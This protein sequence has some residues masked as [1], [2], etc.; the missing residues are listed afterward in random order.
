MAKKKVEQR[1]LSEEERRQ[2]AWKQ[3]AARGR[4]ERNVPLPTES[5]RLSPG[6]EL[7]LGNLEDV[8]VLETSEDGRF[9]LLSY[10]RTDNNYGKPIVTKNNYGVWAWIECFKKSE[11]VDTEFRRKKSLAPAFMNSD[12]RSLLS[13][14]FYRGVI[15]N[16]DYQREYV[17]SQEDKE[18]LIESV[19]KERNLGTFLFVEHP[20]EKYEG[21]LEILDGK[22]RLG[23]LAD[24]Y[25]SKF[26]Y[27]GRYFHELDRMDKHAFMGTMVQFAHLN[28]SRMTKAELLQVF[29]DVNHRGVPQ[30]NEHIKKVERMLE[31]E[32]AKESVAVRKAAKP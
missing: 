14:V 18:A 28:G 23:A 22:Q 17:W 1:E 32:L 15:D 19:F 24:F 27:K 4:E 8:V 2:E 10:T 9:A 3:H 25:E 29:L 16:P 5:R 12:V 30:T 13:T 26:P 20:Y 21:R 31:D 6:D 11:T 7:E